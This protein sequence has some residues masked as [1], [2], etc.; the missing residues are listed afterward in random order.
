M[1]KLAKWALPLLAASVVAACGNLSDVK[2]N[3]TTDEPKWPKIEDASVN[4]SGSQYGTWPNWDNVR[5]IE[6]G[7]NKDQLYY[8]IGR[9]HYQEGLF[10]VR[11]WDYVFNYRQNGV[12]KICQFKV[13]FDTDMNAQSFFW[14]PKGCNN[15]YELNGDFLF[16]FDSAKLTPKGKKV[17]E[18][19]VEGL[20]S[21]GI[22]A[23]TVDGYTD[24]LG[25]DSYNLKLSQRRADAVKAYMANLGF[26]AQNISTH[27]FGKADQVVACDGESGQ[28]LK[29]CL[30]PNRRVVI[31][32][33]Q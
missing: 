14:H 30:R 28:A 6:S 5:Q 17:V 3:G 7:M 20:K 12:H 26:P 15:Q 11:E 25:S 21:Q 1:K 24:R 16:D 33:K 4:F 29:D 10:G 27:G 9:P 13:L 8:L 2:K 31:S 32:A 23:V 18:T 19:V 22:T